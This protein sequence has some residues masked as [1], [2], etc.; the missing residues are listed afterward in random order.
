[1]S[2]VEKYLD[3]GRRS[4][5]SGSGMT[6]NLQAM[7]PKKVANLMTKVGSACKYNLD[8]VYQA[9][10]YLLTDVNAHSVVSDVERIF[11]KDLGF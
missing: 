2:N 3:E 4:E 7:P 9:V 1:M 8:E 11:M 10:L 5:L 6:S